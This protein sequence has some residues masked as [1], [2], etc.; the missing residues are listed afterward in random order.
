LTVC[1]RQITLALYN[2]RCYIEYMKT[3]I[4]TF[5]VAAGNLKQANLTHGCL[6]DGEGFPT[7]VL[8]KR[9]TL[10]NI[11]DDSSQAT[12]QL[13]TCPVCARKVKAA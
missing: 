5:P 9:V 10:E 3:V 4:K 12:D 11:L 1:V 8:C 6:V 7:A 2:A 13:P